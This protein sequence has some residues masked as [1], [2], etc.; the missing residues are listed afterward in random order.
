MNFGHY[1]TIPISSLT[2]L[3]SLIACILVSCAS[4][5]K[6]EEEEAPVAPVKEPVVKEIEPSLPANPTDEWKRL[7]GDT[8]LPT[9]DQLA[10]GA[11]SSM[12]KAPS[13][14][15][16]DERPSTSIKPPPVEPEDQ[17]APSE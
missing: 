16:G 9:S 13:D 7:K 15:L 2:L 6:E 8:D 11:E 17:L 10:D 12:G 1:K 4:T 5:P 14:D 3:T